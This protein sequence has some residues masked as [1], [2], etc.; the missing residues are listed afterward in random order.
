[1]TYCSKKDCYL[2]TV[3]VS[4]SEEGKDKI[5]MRFVVW[6]KV[7]LSLVESVMWEL[8]WN[9]AKVMTKLLR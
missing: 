8:D 7:N 2:D 9:R 5:L 1:M 3:V 6:L 4:W